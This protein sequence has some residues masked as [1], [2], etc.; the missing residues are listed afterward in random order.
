MRSQNGKQHVLRS[1]N[2]AFQHTRFE[3]A[4]FQYSRCTLVEYDV[5][6]VY[7]TF[8]GKRFQVFFERGFYFFQVYKHALQDA[9]CLSFSFSYHSEYQVLGGDVR[10]FQSVCFF[11]A[12]L[13]DIRYS[14]CELAVHKYKYFL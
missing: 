9:Y 3:D 11:F 1:G 12:K 6:I 4:D 7:I 2:F 10:I 13:N 5:V 14:L 8:I